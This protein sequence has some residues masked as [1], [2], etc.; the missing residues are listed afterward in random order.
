MKKIFFLWTLIFFVSCSFDNKTGIWNSGVESEIKDRQ[1]K[2][3]ETLNSSIDIFNEEINPQKGLNIKPSP[4]INNLQ[5]NDQYYQTSNNLDNFSFTNLNKLVF[6]SKRLSKSNISSNLF[7][8]GKNILIVDEK[9]TIVVYS[10]ESQQIVLKYNFYK[11]RF[12]KL[13]KKISSIVDKNII[14]V[15]DNL[16]YFYALNYLTGKLIWAKNYKVPF[17]SNIKIFDQKILVSDINNYLYFINKMDGERVKFIPTEKSVLKNDF[18]NSLSN[19]D[20]S[21]FFLN[22]FGSIY[23][24]NNKGRINWFSNL[25]RAK[26]IDQFNSFYSNPLVLHKDYIIISSE[27]F[28]YILNVVNGSILFKKALPSIVKPIASGDNL[29]LITKQNL[30]VCINLKT[31]KIAYSIKITKEISNFLNSKEKP[32]SIKTFAMLNDTLFVILNN[33]YFINFTLTGEIIEI[34]KLPSK[35][36][37]EPIFINKSMIYLNKQNKLMLVN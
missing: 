26:D 23:S 32:I 35:I 13:R 28:L 30:L 37:S 20:T 33:S 36:Y 18:I 21:L 25:N 19:N 1:F 2:D 12:K 29:F 7:F 10:L 22:T 5:W 15:G 31:N 27:P 14:Y 8:D 17:R 16:G 24:I 3:F 4:L 34:G 11:K 9:G 6:K